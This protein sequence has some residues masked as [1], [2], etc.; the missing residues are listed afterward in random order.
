MQSTTTDR[1][2]K[3]GNGTRQEKHTAGRQWLLGQIVMLA[4]QLDDE[5]LEFVATAAVAMR[6]SQAEA[7]PLQGVFAGGQ[8]SERAR[9]RQAK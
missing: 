6:N 1:R 8:R 4:S 3:R 7:V 9:R 5:R 2:Q